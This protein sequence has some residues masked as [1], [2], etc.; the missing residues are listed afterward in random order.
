MAAKLAEI[1][2][3]P[4]PPKGVE[5]KRREGACLCRTD[6]RAGGVAR[7]D[8]APWGRATVSAS[9]QIAPARAGKGGAAPSSWR[10]PLA[11]GVSDARPELGLISAEISGN[12]GALGRR[13]G[14][15]AGCHLD[16]RGSFLRT[17]LSSSF[18]SSLLP[19]EVPSPFP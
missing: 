13:W 11:S 1:W 6:R 4:G 19:P 3:P 5:A 14:G 2:A 8:L 7:R 16:T 15:A 18:S 17:A 12:L 9:L 10:R